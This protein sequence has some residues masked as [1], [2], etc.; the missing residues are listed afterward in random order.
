MVPEDPEETK[1]CRVTEVYGEQFENS[2]SMEQIF[3]GKLRVSMQSNLDTSYNV[4]ESFL[5]SE[6]AAV[7]RVENS[8]VFE[9]QPTDG[10]ISGWR[11]YIHA[12][13]YPERYDK[14]STNRPEQRQNIVLLSEVIR[15][16][17]GKREG[18]ER[19]P[20]PLCSPQS[21]K[22]ERG[23]MA[24][25]PDEGAVR[26]VGHECAKRHFGQSYDE[27]EQVFERQQRCRR[28]INLW[29]EIDTKRSKIAEILDAVQPVADAVETVRDRIEAQAA[30]FCSFLQRQL[31]QTAGEL[32]ILDDLGQKDQ[33]G[34]AIFQKRII[35]TASGLSYLAPSSRP[36]RALGNARAALAKAE[37]AL[38]HWQASS[39]EHPSTGDILRLG[40]GVA[41]AL[42]KVPDVLDIVRDAQ[43]FLDP[44]NIGLINRWGNRSD[45]A[46]SLFQMERKS[47]QLV[48]RVRSYAGDFFASPLAASEYLNADLPA[49]NDETLQWLKE[50]AA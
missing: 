36:V 25:F 23:R 16:P 21:P 34:E 10:Y 19:V 32:T 49:V 43:S 33:T 14:V 9:G 8:S 3:G 50:L 11:D 44:K 12:T 27:A 4:P 48:I 18:G 47:R 30:G 26:F 39:P 20:C 17:V 41:S 38:P 42:R 29:A 13:G 24:F 5:G 2:K 7:Q 45:T 22:F 1:G 28:Y 40:R 15:V 46:Y 35:G 31:A 6:V 37:A